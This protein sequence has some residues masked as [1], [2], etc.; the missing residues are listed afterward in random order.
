MH[1]LTLFNNPFFACLEASRYLDPRLRGDDGRSL[2]YVIPAKAGIQCINRH[3]P[4]IS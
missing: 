3:L 1:N 4:R 2:T